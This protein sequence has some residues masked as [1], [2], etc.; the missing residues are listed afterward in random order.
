MLGSLVAGRSDKEIAKAHLISSERA[1]S[2]SHAEH[3]D[4][5]LGGRSG[6]V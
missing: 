5:K 2:P 3:I 6:R 1:P 4:A